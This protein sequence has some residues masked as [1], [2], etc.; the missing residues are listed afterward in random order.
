MSSV[1]DVARWCAD[2]LKLHDHF[3]Y[4]PMGLQHDSTRDVQA[5]A[6][7]VSVNSR[8][9]ELA[10]EEGANLLLVHHGTFWNNEARCGEHWQ[11]RFELL[12]RLDMGLLA[13]HI[14]L[15]AHPTIGNNI[16]AA[17]ALGL[18]HLT[19]WEDIGWSGQYRKP[20]PHQ[21]FNAKVIHKFGTQP[22]TFFFSPTPTVSRVA[23]IVGGAAHYVT[24]AKRDGFDTFFTGEPSEPSLHLARDLEMNLIAA[25]HDRTEQSGVQALARLVSREFQVPWTYVPTHNPI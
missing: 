18:G 6:C 10:H 24:N 23:V 12:D 14:A 22:H 17:R 5:I 2:Y 21:V 15:D 11:K 16:L 4:G 7:A 25:G 8:V 1:T 3:D 13:Y 20:M 9:I 19:P